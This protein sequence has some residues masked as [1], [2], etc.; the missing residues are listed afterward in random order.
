MFPPK[1]PFPSNHSSLNTLSGPSTSRGTVTTFG[2]GEM[3]NLAD[4]ETQEITFNVHYN[5]RVYKIPISNT[6]T[7][8]DL[9]NEVQTSTG[10]QVCR[11]ALKGWADNAQRDAQ[12][13]STVLKTLK[14]GKQTDVILT[15]LS[16]EGFLSEI[17]WVTAFFLNFFKDIC[18]EIPIVKFF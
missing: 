17:R 3:K 13:T 12:K 1:L 6:R 4:Q 11:Q 10:V 7:I 14:L 15:D 2:N 5:G 16:D 18:Q 9:K 8:S